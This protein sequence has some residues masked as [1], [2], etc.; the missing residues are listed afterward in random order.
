MNETF[1]LHEFMAQVAEHMGLAP[2]DLSG[3]ER[4]GCAFY[5]ARGIPANTA[6]MQLLLR[7]TWL[8]SAAANKI[9][10]GQASASIT[11]L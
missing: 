4:R 11:L 5:K 7:R 6:G 2:F 8:C 1:T 9:D 3:Y 10:R